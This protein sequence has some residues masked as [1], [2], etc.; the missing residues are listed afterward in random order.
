MNIY[1]YIDSQLFHLYMTP[2]RSGAPYISL[3]STLATP[4]PSPELRPSAVPLAVW[5]TTLFWVEYALKSFYT[6]AL[7][8]SN[9]H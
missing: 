2:I 4:K 3:S 7:L 6:C 8:S 5:S 9:K 1:T